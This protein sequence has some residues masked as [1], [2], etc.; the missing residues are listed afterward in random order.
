MESP[1]PA[2]WYCVHLEY[3]GSG[4]PETIALD[5]QPHIFFAINRGVKNTQC[6]RYPYNDYN[7]IGCVYK[8]SID[9]HK[10]H[11]YITHQLKR[12]QEKHQ[13]VILFQKRFVT[14]IFI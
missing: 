2:C 4:E 13:P 10:I 14:R 1:H 12:R 6:T 8:Y 5:T 11:Q 3:S 7:M 9:Y